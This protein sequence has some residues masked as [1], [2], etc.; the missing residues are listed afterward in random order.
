MEL[1]LKEITELK[2]LLQLNQLHNKEF[3]SVEDTAL[4]LNV[5]KSYLYK[6]TSRKEIPFYSPGGKKIYFKKIEIDEWIT[7]SKVESIQDTQTEVELY[8]SRK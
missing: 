3:F 7:K 8:L 5:S 2:N 1:I 6:L 4:Y